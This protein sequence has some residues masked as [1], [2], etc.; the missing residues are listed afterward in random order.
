MTK[1]LPIPPFAHACNNSR[2]Y[3]NQ[4]LCRLDKGDLAKLHR[5]LLLTL[6]MSTLNE[7]SLII[8]YKL[9]LSV[10]IM[11]KNTYY[12]LPLQLVAPLFKGCLMFVPA[13]IAD[14][15]QQIMQLL[16]VTSGRED[17]SMTDTS[18]HTGYLILIRCAAAIEHE[19]KCPQWEGPTV[20]VELTAETAIVL[21]HIEVMF[22]PYLVKL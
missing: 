10:F 14:N 16:N 7:W 4:V 3:F 12:V 2:G 19:V 15:R 18:P 17:T 8:A 13:K 22:I 21:S 11:N 1:I 6:F 5:C 20:R 9:I